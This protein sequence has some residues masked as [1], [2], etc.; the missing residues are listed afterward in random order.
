MSL[1]S[2]FRV[3]AIILVVAGGGGCEIIRDYDD[4]KPWKIFRDGFRL[5]KQIQGSEKRF[6]GAHGHYGMST[7]LGLRTCGDFYCADLKALGAS[8]SATVYPSSV[9][10]NRWRLFFFTDQSE[11]IRAGMRSVGPDSEPVTKKFITT[12]E[13]P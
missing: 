5:C 1:R 4:P 8:Y 11:V 13:R 6:F 7:D 2:A 9:A 3:S 12:M 10:A